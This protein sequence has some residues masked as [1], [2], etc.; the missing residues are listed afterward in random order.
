M[1][2]SFQSAADVLDELH[3]DIKAGKPPILY[4]IGEGD[5]A[6][7]EVGPKLV[8]LIGGAPNAGKTAFVMQAVTDALRLTPSLRAAVLN[9][10]MPPSSLLDR[11][12]ARL[13]GV[14]LTMIRHRLLKPEH[15]ERI[16]VAVEGLRDVAE[17]LAFVRPP[18]HLANV[19]QTA[20]TVGAGLI[21]L[22]YV[23]RISLPPAAGKQRGPSDKRGV[24]DAMMDYVRQL[25]DC[26]KAI[27][28]VAAVSRTKDKRGRSS[29]DGDGLNLASFRES[30]ELE[31]GAD[32]A[33]MLVPGESASLVTL[34]H[35]KAR[36]TEPADLLLTFDRKHQHFKPYTGDSEAAMDDVKRA[37]QRTA[38]KGAKRCD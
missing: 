17:R 7:I 19:A 1:P 22:D 33:F 26:G 25:A 3:A 35:L 23:Q 36:Y 32:N 31:F 21:C 34:K 9:V 37:W 20:N 8:T 28:L 24:I 14:D 11:Q 2:A 30:S 12:I 27:I 18:F 5:L 16:E 38:A 29:Y 15:A 10:E 6:R 13:S 4:P